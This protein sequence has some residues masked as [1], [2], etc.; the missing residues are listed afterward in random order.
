MTTKLKMIGVL[1]GRYRVGSEVA[2]LR[3]EHQLAGKDEVGCQCRSL[4]P[5]S[6]GKFLGMLGRQLEHISGGF[7]QSLQGPNG[8]AAVGANGLLFT[9]AENTSRIL[10]GMWIKNGT[11]DRMCCHDDAWGCIFS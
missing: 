11:C 4:D 5:A 3:L 7:S 6:N 8:Y 1:I 10:S 9:S 2:D